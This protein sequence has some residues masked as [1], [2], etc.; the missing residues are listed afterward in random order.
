VSCFLRVLKSCLAVLALVALLGGAAPAS[1]GSTAP[2]DRAPAGAGSM[3]PGGGTPAKRGPATMSS[4]PGEPIELDDRPRL[5]IGQEVRRSGDRNTAYL[6]VAVVVLGAMVWWNRRRRD[7]FERDDSRAAEARAPHAAQD[8][9]ADELR[10]AA[11]DDGG[12]APDAVSGG[13]AGDA[14]DAVARRD[15]NG[16][17]EGSDLRDASEGRTSPARSQARERRARET[18]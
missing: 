18:R 3:T 6:G 13:D 11:G 7:R 5:T 8:D 1:A 9:D 17:A 12:D 4:A 10:A 2:G 14:S 15:A 16:G